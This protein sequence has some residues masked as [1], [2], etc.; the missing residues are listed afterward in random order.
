MFVVAWTIMF[1]CTS[2]MVT[3][4]II[5]FKAAYEVN[6]KIYINTVCAFNNN[7]TTQ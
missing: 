1:L 5:S 2:L 6:F 4:W 3:T 7:N